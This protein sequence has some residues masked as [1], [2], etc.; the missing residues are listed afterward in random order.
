M[1]DALSF[2]IHVQC[3]CAVIL[4]KILGGEYGVG[5]EI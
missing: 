3:T 1:Y 4:I 2:Y 5:S